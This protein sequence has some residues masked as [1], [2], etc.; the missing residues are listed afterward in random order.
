MAITDKLPASTAY[1]LSREKYES[2]P[3]LGVWALQLSLQQLGSQVVVDGYFGLAT[4]RRVKAYQRARRLTPDG[5]VGPKT[6]TRIVQGWANAA[7][8]NVRIPDGLL[9]G[10]WK[11]EG[12]GFLVP[13]NWGVAGGVDVGAVQQRV[14]QT[15]AISSAVWNSHLRRDSKGNVLGPDAWLLENARFDRSKIIQ[16]VDARSRL[17]QLALDLRQNHDLFLPRAGVKKDHKTAW[18]YSV[19][20][21]NWPEAADL[22]SRGY[23]LSN[24]EASWVPPAI[25]AQGVNTK[26]EWADWYIKT[27]TRFVP[28]NGWIA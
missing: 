17:V 28:A 18:K 4:E 19:L 8:K 21:H 12:G 13:V 5:I 26:A 15:S 10:I 9:D 14:Y 11:G 27:M 3:D 6:Q 20:D 22:L 1:T 23:V 25:R 2:V 16:A 24:T 7:E